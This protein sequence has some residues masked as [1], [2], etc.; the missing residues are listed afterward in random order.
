MYIFLLR[1]SPGVSL[2]TFDFAF[3]SSCCPLLLHHLQIQRHI[4]QHGASVVTRMTLP[5]GFKQWFEVPANRKAVY[6]NAK[7]SNE[8]DTAA[9]AA[10]NH[11]VVIAGYDNVRECWII[12]S[13]WGP[14]WADGGYARVSAPSRL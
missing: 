9:G 12:W 7:A 3:I 6:D 1:S 4:R 10:V 2:T 13:S 14:Q 8:L 5:A 11:A